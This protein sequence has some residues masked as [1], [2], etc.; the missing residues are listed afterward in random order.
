[1]V[2]RSGMQEEKP[3]TGQK[4]GP[5]IRDAPSV[6]SAGTENSSRDAQ[7]SISGN[8]A[9]PARAQASPGLR[10]LRAL[11]NKSG[12]TAGC[13]HSYRPSLSPRRPPLRSAVRTVHRP[14][15]SRA[16]CY[17]RSQT[18]MEKRRGACFTALPERQTW[19][20]KVEK[21]ALFLI[22]LHLTETSSVL[23]RR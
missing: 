15:L 5:E 7:E 1:M 9:Y 8:G 21:L 6:F 19:R 17:Q 12:E 4:R 2:E 23:K 18:P 13:Q 22:K 10:S 11:P 20:E 16:V 14:G 3:D